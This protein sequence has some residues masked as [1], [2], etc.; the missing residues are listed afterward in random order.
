MVKMKN[1]NTILKLDFILEKLNNLKKLEDDRI[2]CRHNLTHFF[3]VA[4]ICYILCLENNINIKKDL[5]YTTA[6][7]HDL[8]R[9]DQILNGINHDIASFDLAKKTLEFTDFTNEEKDM[10]LNAISNH[11]KKI[12]DYL[13]FSSI[14]YKAD[15][16][17][18]D[19]FNCNSYDTCNWSFE[20]KNNQ[21]KY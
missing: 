16:L 19:C 15:K 5:I 2:Y 18:R 14:F 6:I 4:R 3:D 21:I 1:T 9:E 17:S 11:R 8:G 10:I 20:K 7:L 13:S 12:D